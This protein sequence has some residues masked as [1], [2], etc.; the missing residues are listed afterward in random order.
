MITCS[1]RLTRLTS[2]Y[3]VVGGTKFYERAEIKDAVAYLVTLVNPHDVGAFTRIINSPRRGI[4]STSKISRVL[5]HAN[6]RRLGLGGGLGARADRWPLFS[7]R[8]RELLRL[9]GSSAS[10]GSEPLIRC[11]Q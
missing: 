2:P 11:L 3:Q 8:G 5:A 6:G 10:C 4:G 7:G 9:H 1:R